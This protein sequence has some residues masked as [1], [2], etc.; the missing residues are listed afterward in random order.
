VRD[1]VQ[2]I[3]LEHTDGAGGNLIPVSCS[4][5]SECGAGLVG[6]S[7]AGGVIFLADERRR[8]ALEIPR[9]YC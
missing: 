9:A 4:G 1:A 8:A 5:T 7:A 6:T 2:A 3:T